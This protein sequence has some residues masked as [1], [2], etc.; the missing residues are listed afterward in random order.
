LQFPRQQSQ[1]RR[2]V[3]STCTFSFFGFFE[4]ANFDYFRLPV[5][6]GCIT[7]GEQWAFFI[8]KSNSAGGPGGVVSVASEINL[9]TELENLPLVLGLLRDLVRQPCFFATE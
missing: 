6:R 3:N 1:W 9:G 8:Y 4:L 5:L 2:I 7:S